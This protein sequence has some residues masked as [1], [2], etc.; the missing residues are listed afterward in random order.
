MAIS[1]ESERLL[2]ELMTSYDVD[3]SPFD[4]GDLSF[5]SGWTCHRA[6]PNDTSQTRAAFTIIYMDRDIRLIEAQHDNHLADARLWLPGVQPG[7]IAASK[8]NPVL[9]ER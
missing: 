6:G 5:H 1:D 2:A 4:L 3:E 9:F 7:A 8:L